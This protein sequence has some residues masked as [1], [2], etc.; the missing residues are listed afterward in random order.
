MF[1]VPLKL[2]QR[3]TGFKHDEGDAVPKCSGMS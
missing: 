3:L 2:A 1:E